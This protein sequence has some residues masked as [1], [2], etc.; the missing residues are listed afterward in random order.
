MYFN[1]SSGWE[2]STDNRLEPT[3]FARCVCLPT[4]ICNRVARISYP[5]Y[6]LEASPHYSALPFVRQPPSVAIFVSLLGLMPE[7]TPAW[8]DLID[9]FRK[10]ILA[11]LVKETL[12]FM[13]KFWWSY[14]RYKTSVLMLAFDRIQ[15]I[16]ICTCIYSDK[17]CCIFLLFQEASF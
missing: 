11:R 15:L 2:A 4:C 1:Y 8:R 5:S 16:M 7:V 10:D 12:Y 9:C 14:F 3:A 17:F 13:H 6:P